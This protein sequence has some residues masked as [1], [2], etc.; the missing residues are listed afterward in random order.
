MPLHSL[1][2]GTPC[3]STIRIAKYTALA[4]V[5]ILELVDSPAWLRCLRHTV[6]LAR[7][8]HAFTNQPLVLRRPVLDDDGSVSPPERNLRGSCTDVDV[9]HS[10]IFGSLGALVVLVVG[11]LNA[12][13]PAPLIL[14]PRPRNGL[15]DGILAML[16]LHPA[17]LHVCGAQLI[18]VALPANCLAGLLELGLEITLMRGVTLEVLSARRVTIVVCHKLSTAEVY[19][20]HLTPSA[21]A[22]NL[23]QLV[24]VTCC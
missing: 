21:S 16:P 7:H 8:R 18:L 11:T 20:S 13:R 2:T 3:H 5:P 12:L 4:E 24:A 6:R 19:S 9:A 10:F 15:S 17:P 14:V 22:I 1:R 23:S